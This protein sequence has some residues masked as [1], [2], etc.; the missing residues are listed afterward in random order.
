[1]TA[2]TLARWHRL[3][4][5]RNPAGLDALLS[6]EVVFHSP[7]VHTPQVGKAITTQ[8]LGAAFHVFFNDTF[9]YVREVTGHRDA[10]LE[11][12]VE[13]EGIDVNGVDLIKWDETGRIVEFKVMLRPLKA[14]NLVHR[15]M[16][17][18]LQANP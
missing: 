10:V 9:R 13:I 7:V 4:E 15:K 12:Q 18:M 6:D 16:A 3:V 14:V 2:D 1:M 17:A 11:F 8:Y 5:E